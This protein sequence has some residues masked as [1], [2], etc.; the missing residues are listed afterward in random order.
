MKLFLDY[1]GIICYTSFVLAAISF[2]QIKRSGQKGK[3]LSIICMAVAGVLSLISIMRIV[4]YNRYAS[5]VSGF[6]DGIFGWLG[7]L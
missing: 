4:E 1:Y 3:M 2:S 7:N 5:D 6:L